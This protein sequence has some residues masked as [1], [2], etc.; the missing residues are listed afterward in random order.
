MKCF[1]DITTVDNEWREF[2][3]KT[4]IAESVLKLKQCMSKNEPIVLEDDYGHIN[5]INCNKI[6]NIKVKRI[7]GRK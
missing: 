6:I 1:I 5:I 3:V 7:G 2:A 4:D